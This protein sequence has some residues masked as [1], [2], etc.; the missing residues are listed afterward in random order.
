MKEIIHGHHYVLDD[1]KS[2]TTTD[3]YFYMDPALH[4]GQ[5]QRGPSCQEV[6]RALIARVKA[7]ES[8]KSHPLNEL[9]LDHLR[10]SIILFETRALMLKSPDVE[11]WPVDSDDGH[12][13][14]PR[15]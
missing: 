9:I 15:K 7:L 14:I 5:T 2:P 11:N 13:R 4:N 10:S 8:E 3:L 12:W 1:L 6:I